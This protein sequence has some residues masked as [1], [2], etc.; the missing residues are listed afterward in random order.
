MMTSLRS[1]L[2]ET[3]AGR[4]DPDSDPLLR[5]EDLRIT[6]HDGAATAVRGVSLDVRPGEIVGLVGESGSGKTLTCRAALGVLPPGCA[7]A[8]GT[9]SFAGRDLTGLPP[10]QWE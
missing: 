6:V 3:G 2:P 8:G 10:R 4:I 9:I 7:V 5:I 1:T